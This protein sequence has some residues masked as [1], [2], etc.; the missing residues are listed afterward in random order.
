[1]TDLEDRLAVLAQLYKEATTAVR[2]YQQGKLTLQETS[3]FGEMGIPEATTTELLKPPLKG[4]SDLIREAVQIQHDLVD[5]WLE[6]SESRRVLSELTGISRPTLSR[7][8]N[9]AN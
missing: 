4:I 9:K 6:T 1:M 2:R 7:W 8:Q 3:I 5:E